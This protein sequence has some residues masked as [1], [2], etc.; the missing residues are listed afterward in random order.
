MYSPTTGKA[1]WANGRRRRASSAWPKE[2]TLTWRRFFSETRVSVYWVYG[3]SGGAFDY[4]FAD[5][6]W[7]NMARV[8]RSKFWREHIRAAMLQ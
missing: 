5:W 2:S 3:F 1:A 4:P 8:V 7:P 6:R